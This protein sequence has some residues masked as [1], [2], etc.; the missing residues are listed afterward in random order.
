MS[1]G[2]TPELAESS[3]KTDASLEV[4]PYMQS[5]ALG[6]LTLEPHNPIGKEEGASWML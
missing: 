4:V 6:R 1:L 5:E 2:D 3:Q